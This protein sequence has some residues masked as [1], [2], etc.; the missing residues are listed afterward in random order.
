MDYLVTAGFVTAAVIVGGLTRLDLYDYSGLPWILAAGLAAVLV[1]LLVL[2][3]RRWYGSFPVRFTQTSMVVSLIFFIGVTSIGR[4]GELAPVPLPDGCSSEQAS[5]WFKARLSTIHQ[6]QYAAEVDRFTGMLRR[7]GRLADATERAWAYRERGT[8][9]AL[10]GDPERSLADLQRA[11]ELDPT[12]LY[13]YIV[14]ARLFQAAGC[15]EAGREDFATIVRQY[16]AAED[17]QTLLDAA[18]LLW[19]VAAEFNEPDY[20]HSG[21]DVAE[22][23]AALMISPYEAQVLQGKALASVGRLDEA[24]DVLTL[25]VEGYRLNFEAHLFRGFVNRRLGNTQAAL[26]D[27]EYAI[28]RRPRSAEAR[29]ALGITLFDSGQVEKGLETLNEAV[30][31]DEDEGYAYQW[32]GQALLQY[33]KP[34][35]A[36]ADFERAIL[37]GLDSADVYVG[38]AV[39]ELALGNRERAVEVL[40]EIRNRSVHWVDSPTIM[41]WMVDLKRK[42]GTSPVS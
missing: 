34:E 2:D 4:L 17:G 27:F 36:R 5:E 20:V 32:R 29:A 31:L 11:I 14:R 42:L 35:A 12:E 1:V 38:K 24:L 6:V 25:S 19:D 16:S 41:A 3:Y 37:A 23:A 40:S 30:Q 33:G 9:R 39:A 21:V 13:A 8:S 28:R 10:L 15:L 7:P 18:Q 22:R 26:D